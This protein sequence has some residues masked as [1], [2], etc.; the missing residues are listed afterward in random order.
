MADAVE[1]AFDVT[2]EHP[3][4]CVAFGQRTKGLTN[5][6]GAGAPFSEPVGVA[7]TDCFRNGF[8]SASGQNRPVESE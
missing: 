7:V 6:I 2:F 3:D 5:G 4:R 1:A 8:V